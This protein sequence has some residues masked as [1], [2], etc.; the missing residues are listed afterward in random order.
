MLLAS[1]LARVGFEAAFDSISEK[2]VLGFWGFQ[3]L[4]SAVEP[5]SSSHKDFR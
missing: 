4:D 5:N 2:R 1:L 3:L